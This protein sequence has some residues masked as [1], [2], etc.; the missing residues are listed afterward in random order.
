MTYGGVSW[1]Y[2]QGG[3]YAKT[4]NEQFCIWRIF[5]PGFVNVWTWWSIITCKITQFSLKVVIRGFTLTI[6]HCSAVALCTAINAMLAC[7]GR[8]RY[9]IVGR[10]AIWL[11]EAKFCANHNTS[12]I[13]RLVTTGGNRLGFWLPKIVRWQVLCNITF[14]LVFYFLY[15]ST[16]QTGL[17]SCTVNG[18]NNA[19]WG[20]LGTWTTNFIWGLIYHQ[21]VTF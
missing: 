21:K 9:S 6:S 19:I 3:R 18:S 8:G 13:S 17:P 4:H 12:E 2:I 11:I 14:C 15:S 5:P 16:A 10:L 1:N 20:T 7:N